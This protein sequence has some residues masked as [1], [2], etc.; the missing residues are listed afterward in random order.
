MLPVNLNDTDHN[1]R[2]LIAHTCSET[3]YVVSVKFHR[4]PTPF[5]LVEMSRRQESADLAVRFGGSTFGTC[6]LVHLEHKGSS[7]IA[8]HI[9][10]M[11][12]TG[13]VT[14]D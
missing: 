7:D 13:V 5:A 12:C 1:V 10:H 2:Q 8:G 3:G 11:K 6:A 9:D 14:A 4:L